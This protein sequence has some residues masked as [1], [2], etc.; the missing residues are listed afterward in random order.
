MLFDTFP[1][2]PIRYLPS[3][4]YLT[5]FEASAVPIALNNCRLGFWFLP[6]SKFQKDW[7]TSI[8][9]IMRSVGVEDGGADEPRLAEPRP[10]GVGLGELE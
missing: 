10:D 3:W 4:P 7:T 5:R 6:E 2:T 1:A 9:V 8:R